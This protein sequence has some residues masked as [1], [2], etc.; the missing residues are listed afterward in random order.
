MKK[1]LKFE[2][3]HNFSP[4]GEN[5]QIAG[6]SRK[7]GRRGGHC[8]PSQWAHQGRTYQEDVGKKWD[9][10]GPIPL[11]GEPRQ[12]LIKNN[13]H[14]KA[15]WG[16]G[17]TPTVLVFM[18]VIS[19]TTW[20]CTVCLNWGWWVRSSASGSGSTSPAW[21]C[22]AL[23]HSPPQSHVFT[24]AL[25]YCGRARWRVGTKPSRSL[26]DLRCRRM[27]SRTSRTRLPSLARSG[28]WS[29][30]PGRDGGRVRAERRACVCFAREKFFFSRQRR[31]GQ[32][33]RSKKANI[34]NTVWCKAMYRRSSQK[35]K[36]GKT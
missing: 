5:A 29:C 35:Q 23:P 18:S 10:A 9:G 8:E 24:L 4:S 33:T 3:Q 32:E 25:F 12:I 1:K 34:S 28:R 31:G 2:I 6:G 21:R 22:A 16:F 13:R 17:F 30:K 14:N 11:S 27:W 36:T 7:T 20:C 19:S 15:S 26:F